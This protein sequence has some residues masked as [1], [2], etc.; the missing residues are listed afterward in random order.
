MKKLFFIALISLYTSLNFG[1]QD[2]TI[3]YMDN[4]P[5]RMYS[6]PAFKPKSKVNIGLPVISSIYVSHMNTTLTPRNLFNTS[7]ANPVLQ[8]ES[9]KSK[10]K[11]NNYLGLNTKIDLF[12]LGI[13]VKKNYFSFNATE[14]INFRMNLPKGMLLL[15]LSG[16]ASFD[17]HGGEL[18]FKN[19]GVNANH[20]REYGF[21]WQR[22][23][24]DKLNVGAKLKY[25]YGMENI[26]T[27]E[28]NYV[29]T[30]D[31][32]TYDWTISGNMDIRSSGIP[33]T[34]VRDSNG[35]LQSQDVTL[36]AENDVAAYLL[37]RKNRG[38]GIDFGGEYKVNDKLSVNASVIDLGFINWKDYNNRF[39]TN[40]TDF[41]FTGLDFTEIIYT[42][43]S[44]R[45]D[46]IDALG[47]KIV[48]D[49]ENQS[50]LTYSKDKYSTPLLTRIHLGGQYQL[51]KSDKTA[52]KAGLLV[53]TEI[54][55][56][57]IRP[58][59]TL[60][61]N[62]SVGRWLNASISYSVINR[63]WENIGAGLSMNLG[64]LQL[65]VVA[66]N[67]LAGNMTKFTD[68]GQS[69]FVYPTSA[70]YVQVHTGINLTFGRE[71][72]DRDKDGIPDKKD[73][74]PDVFGLE[75]FNGC[76]DTDADGVPD[77][78]DECPETPGTIGGCPDTDG[79]GIIDKRDSCVNV[80]GLKEFNGCPDTDGDGIMDIKDDCPEVAGL[81]KF[82]GCPDTDKDGVMD[83]EDE[84]PD[85]A[86]P[87][88]L[89]G[90]PDTD[91]DGTLDKDDSCPNQFGPKENKG[92]PWGD[93]DNDGLTDDV[94]KCPEEF[95]TKENNGCPYGDADGDGILDNVDKCPNVPGV[96]ENDGCPEI[97][98][99]EQE[100]LKKA[101][102]NLEFE[103][104]KD[105]IKQSSYESLNELADVLKKRPEWKLKISGHTDNVGAAST[106]LNLSKKRSL[107]VKKFLMDRG[108]EDARLRPEWFGETKPIAPNDTPEGRQKNRRVEMSIEFE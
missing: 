86:G 17:E 4:I 67:I 43:D 10:I 96:K 77:K 35:N 14:N 53:Q 78:D 83:K 1:Q 66:D 20:Y 2:L 22:E 54:Y 63:S 91:G 44:S 90:C 29:W 23:W 99:E 3:Y 31:P 103:T 37:K 94:D 32:D 52:G 95:G 71:K 48:D 102:D 24:S 80:A 64:A 74:C 33:V 59:F 106:N 16:N 39:K 56:K 72:K 5:Q 75:E 45:Q 70:K 13:Q 69:Q 12:S 25:L 38:L 89:K 50:E 82:N 88:E 9:F 84:C 30:T 57:S 101:F 8:T 107:A 21:G 15:P 26:Y 108:I 87:I 18:S 36:D 93:K 104:G 11:A 58:S 79:D 97:K 19:F 81:E 60:S 85:V 27:K 51:Y 46:S 49:F 6:N 73:D 55:H 98:K 41:A 40:Q 61:Y 28:S 105:V 34:F 100:V 92:C 76:P 47:K 7:G 62:Q 68:N 65:Y 42:P